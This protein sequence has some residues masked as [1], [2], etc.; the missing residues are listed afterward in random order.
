[1][2]RND[3]QFFIVEL[4]SGR[5]AC[6]ALPRW[7]LHVPGQAAQRRGRRGLCGGLALILQTEEACGRSDKQAATIRADPTMEGVMEVVPN[8]NRSK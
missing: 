2:T 6:I 8:D 4:L 7:S 3:A 5:G 1:M